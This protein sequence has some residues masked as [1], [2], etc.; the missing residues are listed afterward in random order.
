MI[1]TDFFMNYFAYGFATKFRFW[2]Y[3]NL[4]ELINFSSPW[5]QQKIFSFFY[6]FRGKKRQLSCSNLF[7]V[8]SEIWRQITAFDRLLACRILDIILRALTIVQRCYGIF[9]GSIRFGFYQIVNDPRQ[10]TH[11]TFSWLPT[12]PEKIDYVKASV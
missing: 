4:S 11:I 7:N 6:D 8:R 3:A 5:N 10:V 9:I 2:Y 12:F 1:W